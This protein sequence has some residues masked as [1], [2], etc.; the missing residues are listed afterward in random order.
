MKKGLIVLAVIVVLLVGWQISKSQNAEQAEPPATQVAESQATDSQDTAAED[1][2]PVYGGVLRWHEVAN[3]PKL[4]VHMATDTTSARVIYCIF[5]NLVTNSLDGQNVIPQL[6]ESWS[7]SEDGL[8]WT[9]SLRKGV[10][11]HK[12]TEGGKPTENGGREVTAEDWKWTFERMIRDNSPRAYFVD[13]I[14][15]YDEMADGNAEEWSGI[16]AVDDYTLEFTLKQ[17]FSPFLTVLSYNSFGV[18]PK[19]DVEKWGAD[20]NFHP[21]GTGPF[22]FEEWVQDQRVTLKKNPEYWGKDED[23]NQLPYLDGWE[24]V[25]IPDG[26]VA[27]EEFKKGNIDI[28]RDVPDNLV[29]DARSLLGDK[30]LDG[31]QPGTYYFGF[32]M[33]KEPFKSNKALRHA[34]NYAV[35]RER[36]ND[37]VLEGL[38]FPAKG[39]LPPS[40][41]GY[42][43]N[44]ESYSYDPEK[45]KELLTEAGFPDGFETTLQVNQNVRHRAIAEAVQAQVA[46][47]GIK[48]NVQMVDWGVHLD[49][50]D[51]GEYDGMY[52]MGWVVDYLDPDNFLYVNLHSSNFGAKGNYSFYSNPEADKLMEEGRTETDPAKRVEIYQKAEQTIVDDAPW[53][54][55][56]YYYNNIATQKWVNGATLPAF[57]NYTARMD[58]VWMAEK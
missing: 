29:S 51:R 14:A 3:P 57:G 34:L 2:K 10:R 37:L 23:G 47:L 9:F 38:W 40:M 15:G 21:V 8:T 36:I 56:F 20:F 25:V 52:R 35:D 5:E 28:M 30:M 55:L 41:P 12:E 39:I 58:N 7:A 13:C 24:L 46:E 31:P 48:L 33:Q 18:V 26:T 32:N 16:R 45:A 49:T 54:F 4:D 19:E 50:L 1:G 53:L 43:P 27:W 44:L 11:F 17:P 42:N 6:A 22:V